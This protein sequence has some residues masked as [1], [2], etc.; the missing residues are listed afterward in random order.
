MID[1]IRLATNTNCKLICK[2]SIIFPA[3]RLRNMRGLRL[4]CY[5][6]GSTKAT[7]R[8]ITKYKGYRGICPDCGSNW[9][10]S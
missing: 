8:F 2:V 5:G 3:Y 9:P 7:I 6:C 4:E 1:M 10:E